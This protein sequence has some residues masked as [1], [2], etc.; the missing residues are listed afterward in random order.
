VASPWFEQDT[1]K[2]RSATTLVFR[3]DGVLVATAPAR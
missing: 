3:I 2:D 1:T